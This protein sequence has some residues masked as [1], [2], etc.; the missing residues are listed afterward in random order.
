MNPLLRLVRERENFTMEKTLGAIAKLVGGEVRGDPKVAI[1]GFSGIKE[2]RE[3]DLTFLA[4]SKYGPLLETT[5]ASAV[6][7][8]LDSK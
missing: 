1:T 5:K 8:P 4:N 3:G 2:A 7:V 6:I